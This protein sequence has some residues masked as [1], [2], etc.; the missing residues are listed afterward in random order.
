MGYAHLLTRRISSGLSFLRKPVTNTSLARRPTPPLF[1]TSFLLATLKFSARAASQRS[2]LLCGQDGSA[3]KLSARS[4]RLA[5]LLSWSH[6]GCQMDCGFQIL[7]QRSAE[8]LYRSNCSASLRPR[9]TQNTSRSRSKQ[10]DER[11]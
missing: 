9:C 10:Y 2:Q 3:R 8:H 11:K 6:K 7:W 5:V 4:R 1:S